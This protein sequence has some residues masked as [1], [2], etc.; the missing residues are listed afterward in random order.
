MSARG[1]RET[2]ERGAE[3]NFYAKTPAYVHAR[4]RV[5]IANIVTQ[6]PRYIRRSGRGGPKK[7]RKKWADDEIFYTTHINQLNESKLRILSPRAHILWPYSLSVLSSRRGVPNFVAAGSQNWIMRG[8][9]RYG[10]SSRLISR[11]SQLVL[12]N[13]YAAY[14]PR[15]RACVRS[16]SGLWVWWI[17]TVKEKRSNQKRNKNVAKAEIKI[18]GRRRG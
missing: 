10:A 8:P 5:V 15:R 11:C 4:V 6:C 2:R 7:K 18:K 12:W 16:L 3:K 1:G 13:A 9:F 14:L 17:R